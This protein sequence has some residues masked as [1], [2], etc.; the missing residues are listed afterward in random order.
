MGI[1]KLRRLLLWSIVAF[2]LGISHTVF[3]YTV[4]LKNGKV[5]QG[6]LVSED[7]QQ[8]VLR[9]ASVI[10]MN[11]KKKIIDLEK[12]AFINQPVQSTSGISVAESRE[13][14]PEETF[15]ETQQK[16]VR[17]FTK[18][19]LEELRKKYD[20]GESSQTPE[21][22]PEDE[23][24]TSE[25]IDEESAEE[26]AETSQES[27]EEPGES[28]VEPESAEKTEEYWK[29]R[30][31]ELSTKVAAAQEEYN[32]LQNQCNQT[33]GITVQTHVLVDETG[34]PM[35]MVKAREQ[36]CGMSERAKARFQDAEQE[37]EQFLREARMEGVPPGW[38]RHNE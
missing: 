10:Q 12:T 32:K 2:C 18:A 35:D 27:K 8:I 28:E 34:R 23:S 13:S 9:E 24:E 38:V 30:Y 6:T 15:I 4:V 36:Y 31:Q 17:V 16:P 5:I 29:S 26:E 20:W 7:D 11:F 14:E 25:E 22:A 3:S 19:D 37:F 33:L 1:F 21:E